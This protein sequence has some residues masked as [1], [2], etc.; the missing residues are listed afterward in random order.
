MD[1]MKIWAAL[2]EQHRERVTK[3]AEKLLRWSIT[4]SGEVREWGHFLEG[5]RV[6][7]AVEE[8]NRHLVERIDANMMRI[9]SG[10]KQA[11]VPRPMV[12]LYVA[13][14]KL[15]MEIEA[16]EIQ[17]K[18]EL[19]VVLTMIRVQSTARLIHQYNLSPGNKTLGA[20]LRYR[21]ILKR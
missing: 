15:A 17:Q 20:E 8:E 3:E 2:S 6:R 4:W 18:H 5:S 9:L 14:W 11:G 10:L 1:E 7:G 16:A 12:P 21:G 13:I 19:A